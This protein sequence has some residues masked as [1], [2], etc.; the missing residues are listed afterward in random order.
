M[1]Y[2]NRSALIFFYILV[3]FVTI[4]LVKTDMLFI[5]MCFLIFKFI[6]NFI[7][8]VCVCVCVC[9]CAHARAYVI[10]IV[11]LKM[12]KRGKDMQYITVPH[13]S[14][15][16]LLLRLLPYCRRA[17]KKEH[18]NPFNWGDLVAGHYIEDGTRWQR[19][20]GMRD[21]QFAWTP[22]V[23]PRTLALGF[24]DEFTEPT[25]V[26]SISRVRCFRS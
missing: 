11:G 9:V 2:Y 15:N 10:D 23:T 21:P 16:V 1:A 14:K 12:W 7:L 5:K 17:R 13:F 6:K 8:C 26:S 4:F 19:G 22:R 20:G 3:I 18:L 24:F 25:P